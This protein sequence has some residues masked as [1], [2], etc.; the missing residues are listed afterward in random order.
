MKRI[1]LSSLILIIILSGL[2]PEPVFSRLQTVSWEEAEKY[3]GQEVLVEGTIVRTFNSGRA[4]FLNFHP[5]YDRYLSLVILAADFNKFPAEPERY[6]LNKKVEVRG[7]VMLYR[8]RLEIVL[9]SPAQVTITGELCGQSGPGA[10]D[11]PTRA[12]GEVSRP[13]SASVQ[14]ISWEEAGN[15]YDQT[16]WV[17]GTVVAANNTG[18]VCF[19]NFHR[20]WRRYFTA[21][22]FASDFHRFPQPPEKLY[23]NREVRVYGRIREYQ[24]KPEIIVNRPEQIEIIR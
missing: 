23:L 13:D 3:V 8:N 14:E 2:G 16:V 18:K 15:Y 11:A 5:D 7:R 24:G 1:I 17:R 10:A 19:L 22:I 20:N 6:Y 4:C 21:V 9:N 12:R